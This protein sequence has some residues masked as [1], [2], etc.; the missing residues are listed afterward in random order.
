MQLTIDNVLHFDS[1]DIDIPHNGSATLITGQNSA[2]KTSLSKILAAL[3]THNTNPSHLS[4]ALTKAYLKKGSTQGSAV[5]GDVTWTVPKTMAIPLGIVPQAMDHCVGI[6]NFVS[7]Q[8]TADSRAA[9]YESLFLPDDPEAILRPVW[10][11]TDQQ[12]AQALKAIERADGD[13]R[14]VANVYGAQKRDAGRVWGQVTGQNYTPKRGAQWTP[15]DWSSDLEGLSEDDVLAALNDAQAALRAVTV[16]HAV[17]QD[18]IDRAIQVRDAELP[19]VQEELAVGE[20]D[21]EKLTEKQRD[22][23]EAAKGTGENLT[24]FETARNDAVNALEAIDEEIER[25]LASVADT[26]PV[27][28]SVPCPHCEGRLV[29]ALGEVQAYLPKERADP[30]ETLEELNRRRANALVACEDA[31]KMLEKPRAEHRAVMSKYDHVRER[32]Q[33]VGKKVGEGRA[34]VKVLQS[35]TKDADLTVTESNAAEISELENARDRADAQRK[36]WVKRRDADAAHNNYT[37]YAYLEKLLG[38][39]G[40]RAEYMKKR[41]EKLRAAVSNVCKR[42]Y[43]KTI[44]ISDTYEVLSDGIPTPLAAENERL[45]AQWVIQIAIAMLNPGNKWIILDAAD[46]LRGDHWRGLV[47]VINALLSKRPYLN[48]VVCATESEAPEEWNLITL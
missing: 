20:R 7:G 40:A 3:V 32:R 13:W 30:R 14:S 21:L 18:R 27:D 24:R 39:N 41:M 22:L 47:T 38:P 4:A 48:I 46:L 8:G 11:G 37:E 17:D 25:I 34:K 43:W 1:L 19:A 6:V 44:T 15:D 23:L 42:A 45:K 28:P 5:F 16:R 26:E 29:V 31:K 35:M 36:A 10:K 33:A 2:G 9:L 12:L